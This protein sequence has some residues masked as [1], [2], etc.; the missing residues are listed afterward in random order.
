V[1]LRRKDFVI[2]RAKDVPSINGAAEQI[3]QLAFKH[4]LNK[5]FVATDGTEKGGSLHKNINSLNFNPTGVIG[6][7]F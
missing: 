6:I 7:N 3:K 1:H 2:G 5:I 4:G